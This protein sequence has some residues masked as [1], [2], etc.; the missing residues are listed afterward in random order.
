[1]SAPSQTTPRKPC[2]RRGCIATG[3]FDG[4]ECPGS[5]DEEEMHHCNDCGSLCWE[6]KGSRCERCLKYWC[7]D[8]QHL[9][10]FLDCDHVECTEEGLCAECFLVDPSLW[11][12]DSGCLC[13]YKEAEVRKTYE[14]FLA[15]GTL[16]GG[17]T[18]F[19]GPD[20]RYTVDLYRLGC[21]DKWRVVAAEGPGEGE[22]QSWVF[23]SVETAIKKIYTVVA[24]KKK[25]GYAA[26]VASGYSSNP[27]GYLD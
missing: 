16:I 14:E 10:I 5:D 11:C 3:H 9:F 27:W 7:V 6:N 24:A 19:R 21:E 1:M 20:S 22:G 26:E 8:W 25:E 12:T 4:R 2:T 17:H 13:S 18:L 15:R 23:A